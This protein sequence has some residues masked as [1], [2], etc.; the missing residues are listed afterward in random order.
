MIVR[1]AYNPMDYIIVITRQ[2][3]MDLIEDML[4]SISNKPALELIQNIFLT[5]Q[6]I[7]ADCPSG[8]NEPPGPVM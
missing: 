2:Q 1:I 4:V 8:L 6:K 5:I 3:L 7:H